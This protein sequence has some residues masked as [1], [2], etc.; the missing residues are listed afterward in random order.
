MKRLLVIAVIAALA[1]ALAAPVQ[2]GGRPRIGVPKFYHQLPSVGEGIA[3]ILTRELFKCGRF[4][5]I[6]RSELETL[7]SEVDF[8][9]SAYVESSSAAPL[10]RIKGVDYLLIG[11]IT[12]FGVKE[13]EAGIG[14]GSFGRNI[15]LG[16]LKTEKRIAY[17]SFDIRL[18]EVETGRVVFADTAD[19]EEKNSGATL[20]MGG[21]NWVAGINFGSNEFRESMIGKATY[22]AIGKVLL[23]LYEEFPLQGEVL[24]RSGDMIVTNLSKESGL[25]KGAMLKVLRVNELTDDAGNV[26]WESTEEIGT[27]RIT[28]FQGMNCLAEIITG[29]NDIEAGMRVCP[30]EEAMYL[31]EEAKAEE[32]EE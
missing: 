22:K 18:V 15:G 6:E 4:D 30:V 28:E 7:L 5:V 31:P 21:S 10:G 3:D 9:Q 16:G 14:A 26:V 19:G 29:R 1:V 17:A 27:A 12:A 23:K 11:K 32:K 25:E 24:A 13:K 8:E 20:I 2:A